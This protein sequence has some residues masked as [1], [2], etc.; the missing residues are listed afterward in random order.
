MNHKEIIESVRKEFQADSD[1]F[2]TT[3]Q[4]ID[5]LRNKYLG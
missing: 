3:T 2:P 5:A 4:E 1:P